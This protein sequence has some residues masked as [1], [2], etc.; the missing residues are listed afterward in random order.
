MVLFR[1]LIKIRRR[2]VDMKGAVKPVITPGGR[3]MRHLTLAALMLA[4][5][6]LTL[7][8]AAHAQ[9]VGFADAIKIL[10]SSCGADI[11]KHCKSVNIGNGRIQQCLAENAERIS[12]QCKADYV[13]V[14][15]SLEARFAAQSA[16]SKICDRDARQYCDGVQPG[17]GHVLRCLLKA[18]PSVSEAC[19]QAITDA[20][21]R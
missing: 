11:E 9:T 10:H 7:G 6:A 12:P 18:E 14:Y 13:G 21:Y 16:V 1:L 5:I 2:C 8:A 15:L 20:G 4:G 3:T 17:K 19:N